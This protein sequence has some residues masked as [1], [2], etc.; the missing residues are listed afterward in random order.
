MY[1]LCYEYQIFSK[2]ISKRIDN[3]FGNNGHAGLCP[4]YKM[5]KNYPNVKV[6]N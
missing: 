5:S 2:K 4:L 1:D 6:Y 3:K